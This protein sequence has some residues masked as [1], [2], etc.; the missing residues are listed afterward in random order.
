MIKN[1]KQVIGDYFEQLKSRP[2]SFNLSLIIIGILVVA[3]TAGLAAAAK[4]QLP[5]VVSAKS[6]VDQRV[7]EEIAISFNQTVAADLA[8][9]IEPEVAGEFKVQKTLLGVNGLIF[10][11]QSG[12]L[13]PDTEYVIKISGLNRITGQNLSD[14]GVIIKTEK[15]PI[16]LGVTPHDGAENV[17]INDEI[18]IT[19]DKS[20][21]Q[22][23]K[24]FVQ[25]DP[26]LDF[27]QTS[28]QEGKIFKWR[29]VQALKQGQAYQVKVY[30]EFSLNPDK[31]IIVSNFKVVPEPQVV[32]ATT[33]D[34]FYPGQTID[35]EFDSAMN[36]DVPALQ[37][38]CNGEGKWIHD[39]RFQFLPSG[40]EVAK[41]YAYKIPAGL[42]S[43]AGGV[44]E[45]DKTYEIKTPGN[46]VASFTGLGSNAATNSRITVSF[47]QAVDKASVEQRFSL[48]PGQAGS[49][50]WPNATTM[51]FSPNGLQQQTSYTVSLSPGIKPQ[52]FGLDS[53]RH[54]S[55]SFKTAAPS[56][57]LN[58]P[59]LRQQHSSSCEAAALRMALAFRGVRDSDFGIVQRMGYNG[60]HMNRDSGYWDDPFEM[61]VGDVNGRQSLYQGYG[62]YAPP[63]VKAAQS[64][65]RN[66]TAFYNVSAQFIAEQIHSGNPVIIIGTVSGMSPRYTSWNGPNGVVHAWI[67]EH[68][69]TVIG[70]TGKASDPISFVVNDPNTGVQQTWSPG[71]LMADINAIPQ[72]PSQVVVVY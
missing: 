32:A 31:P 61:Y 56:V 11:P 71:R 70:V 40:I 25:V 44:V 7:D 46:V 27:V 18:V 54:F 33:S 48:T 49:F 41:I 67:G 20:N 72:L 66:A 55:M 12:R 2:R 57:K 52:Q 36:K 4:T 28:E 24:L 64:Y 26:H 50:S 69:R 53:N 38:Q 30:D 37:C 14:V 39:K 22:L 60:Q 19:L 29:P 68:A 1:L 63:I 45:A 43:V 58:V 35:V 9:V 65:G 6:S 5:V 13:A 8:P 21:R 34:H 3:V 15:A 23:R 10:R 51:V 62:A 17:A 16:I 42:K 59:V 47:D